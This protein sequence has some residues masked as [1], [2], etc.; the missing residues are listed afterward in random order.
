MLTIFFLALFLQVLAATADVEHSKQKIRIHKHFIKETMDQNFAVVLEHIEKH[1]D[2]NVFLTEINANIEK[3]EM[4]LCPQGNS[5]LSVDKK[6]S[7]LKTELFFDN[8]QIVMEIDGLAYSG[9]GVITDP[10]SGIQET[11]ELS[12]VLDLA[13]IVMSPDQEVS[14]QGYVYPKIDIAEVSFQLNNDNFMVQAHGDLPLYK[15]RKFEEGIKNW[16]ISQIEERQKQ[17]REAL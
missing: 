3:L 5:S 17:F 12:A 11:I 9:A 1:Q 4:K 6:W 2:K 15:S 10:A 7:E 16:M 13:Q 14:K 8:G